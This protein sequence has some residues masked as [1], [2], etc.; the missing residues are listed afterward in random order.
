VGITIPNPEQELKVGM[1]AAL[2]VAT[3]QELMAVTVVLAGIQRL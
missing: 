1:I 2:E 3:G